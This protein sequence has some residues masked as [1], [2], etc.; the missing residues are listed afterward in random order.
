MPTPL[1]LGSQW[2]AMLIIVRKCLQSCGIRRKGKISISKCQG[3]QGVNFLNLNIV[4]IYQD[5][6]VNASAEIGLEDYLLFQEFGKCQFL[7][8]HLMNR[9]FC[10]FESPQWIEV[11]IV[12]PTVGFKLTNA[13]FDVHEQGFRS[14]YTHFFNEFCC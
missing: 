5:M 12:H 7:N 4:T 1:R 8:N 9:Q 10:Y 13:R 6:P 2:N 3:C 14:L 11:R